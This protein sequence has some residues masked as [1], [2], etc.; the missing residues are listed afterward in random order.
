M[1]LVPSLQ[2]FLYP[3]EAEMLVKH[4]GVVVYVQDKEQFPAC[5]FPTCTALLVQR[6]QIFLS[7]QGHTFNWHIA[8]NWAQ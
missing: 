6:G 8:L 7:A 3:V 2:T 4:A 1:P 5:T